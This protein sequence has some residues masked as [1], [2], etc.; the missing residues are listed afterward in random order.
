MSVKFNG[1]EPIGD[2]VTVFPHAADLFKAHGIDFCCGGHRTLQDALQ[3]SSVDQEQ[4]LAK[5]NDAYAEWNTNHQ[6]VD[7]TQ[8]DL[9]R[10]ID[11]IVDVHHAYTVRELPLI[12]AWMSKITKV[13]GHRH[14]DLY[15]VKR[16]FDEMNMELSSHLVKEEKILFPLIRQFEKEASLP[17]LNQVIV[18]LDKMEAEHDETGENLKTIRKIT[19]GYQAPSDACRSYQ[20]TYGKLEALE[21]DL[22]RHIHLENHILFKRLRDQ[23]MSD[24]ERAN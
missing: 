20:V 2:I 23:Q 8:A 7:W 22:H 9:S 15:E 1:N 19:N 4:M 5:L 13:H 18:I 12:E 17:I 21:E 6:E 24:A 3:K 14:P 10:L 16:L 11:H